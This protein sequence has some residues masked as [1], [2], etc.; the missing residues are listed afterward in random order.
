M[1]SDLDRLL[2]SLL[3]KF[4]IEEH[5]FTG[6][7][8]VFEVFEKYPINI[9]RDTVIE[10]VS[11]L[12]DAQTRETGADNYLADH[13][14]KLNIDSL[15]EIRDTKVVDKIANVQVGSNEVTLYH[16]ASRY[17]NHHFPDDYPVYNIQVIPICGTLFPEIMHESNSMQGN[18]IYAD[19]KKAMILVRKGL[20][21]EKLN[22]YELDK[23][24]WAH[25]SEIIESIG[26]EYQ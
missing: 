24:L 20:H 8:R 12:R 22:F 5:Y 2:P 9:D 26:E 19:F 7:E 3:E 6:D 13:I 18:I 23:I 16:F 11:C 21:L 15:L 14:L 1:K 4:K 10:K 17:C 25:E